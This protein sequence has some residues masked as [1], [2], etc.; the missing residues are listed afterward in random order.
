MK[1]LLLFFFMLSGCATYKSYNQRTTGKATLRGGIFQK[2]TWDDP[3]VFTRM[4]WYHGMTLY[5]DALVYPAD[6]NS[7]FFKWFSA[8]EKEYLSKCD[9]LLVTMNYSA[10]PSK[11]SHVNFREQM[12]QNGYDEVVIN[13]FASFLK[14]HPAVLDWGVSNYRVLGY[15]KRN[16]SRLN[17]SGLVINF[18][19]F[20]HLEVKL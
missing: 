7:P 12:N 19:S 16:L 4:S 3:L 2:E 6:S 14:G 20:K 17:S 15:C 11:I 9:K 10:D 18:P 8:S 1:Y 5:Y 13:T